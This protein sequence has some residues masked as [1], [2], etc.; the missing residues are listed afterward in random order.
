MHSP[1]SR[2]AGANCRRLPRRYE[3]GVV[4]CSAEPKGRRIGIGRYAKTG[5]IP[6]MKVVVVLCLV[7]GTG[8]SSSPS[9]PRFATTR[10]VPQSQP[11]NYR[12]AEEFITWYERQYIHRM[13]YVDGWSTDVEDLIREMGLTRTAERYAALR[14][15]NLEYALKHPSG[16]AIPDD[17]LERIGQRQYEHV[18]ANTRSSKKWIDYGNPKVRRGIVDSYKQAALAWIP[19]YRKLL[20]APAASPAVELQEQIKSL[21]S[22]EEYSRLVDDTNQATM[23]FHAALKEGVAWYAPWAPWVKGMIEKAC[24]QD[25]AACRA[26]VDEIYGKRK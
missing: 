24:R 1:S 11:V 15:V 9:V 25:L 26:T 21:L 7:F 18:L 4:T 22:R 13:R 23:V 6:G 14:K 20:S 2:R 5:R 12:L 16:T 10:A 17:A 8:V 3:R 19:F